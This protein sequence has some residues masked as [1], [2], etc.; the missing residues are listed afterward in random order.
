MHTA[1]MHNIEITYDTKNT[2][3]IR[4]TEEH[5]PTGWQG[6]VFFV[7]KKYT[8]FTFLEFYFLR[9]LTKNVIVKYKCDMCVFLHTSIYM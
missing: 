2:Y 7:I 6:T 8:L 4:L 3:V 5:K 1:V 9:V